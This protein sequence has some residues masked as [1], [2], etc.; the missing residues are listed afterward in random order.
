MAERIGCDMTILKL[1][2]IYKILAQ[3]GLK[4]SQVKALLPEWWDDEVGQTELGVWEFALIIARRL[5]IDANALLQGNISM[6]GSV[7]RIAFKHRSTISSDAYLAS[8]MMAASLSEAIN[9]ASSKPFK[10]FKAAAADLRNQIREQNEGV[11]DFNGLLD[12]C[13]ENGLPVIPLP[14]LPIGVRKMDGAIFYSGTRPAIVISRKN[15]SKAW[16][17]FIL[18]HEIGHYCLSHLEPGGSI[19]DADLK[20]DLTSQTES[21]EDNQEREADQFALDLLGGAE[22]DQAIDGWNPR[23]TGVSLAVNARNDATNAGSAAGHLVLRH[24]FKTKRWAESQAALNFLDE[25]FDAQDYLVA[26]LKSQIDLELIAED[27]QNMVYSI[28]G[29]QHD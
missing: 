5:S 22:A 24:A 15:D 2:E 17:S 21:S 20:G 19:I 23:S 11:V 1:G 26:K 16:L 27:L 18:A 12:F 8:S 14:N 3:L 28:T 10:S 6:I 13:W 4:K 7:S 29:M 9:A 25:D